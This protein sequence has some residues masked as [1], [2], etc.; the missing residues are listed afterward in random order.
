MNMTR[1]AQM[2]D[3]VAPNILSWTSGV[4]PDPFLEGMAQE[5]FRFKFAHIAPDNQFY[6]S[7]LDECR[8]MA[9]RFRVKCLTMDRVNPEIGSDTP[10]WQ[11]PPNTDIREAQWRDAFFANQ[12][13]NVISLH[14]WG[15]PLLRVKPA[16]RIDVR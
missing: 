14:I 1:V 10:D 16:I 11:V 2:H 5:L 12:L 7:E 3:D 8:Q 9:I 13:A 4:L 15:I 6:V